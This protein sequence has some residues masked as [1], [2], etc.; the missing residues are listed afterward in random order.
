MCNLHYKLLKKIDQ[1]GSLTLSEIRSLKLYDDDADLG[2]LLTHLSTGKTPYIIT[3]TPGDPTWRITSYGQD[4]LR[5]ERWLRRS[6]WIMVA[7][8]F[9]ALSSLLC[10]VT[11]LLLPFLLPLIV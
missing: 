5:T 3:R 6:H 4:A 9:V 10:S 1:T 2:D 11:T 8:F 7:T